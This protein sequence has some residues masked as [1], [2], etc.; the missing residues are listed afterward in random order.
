MMG[1]QI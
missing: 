1:I